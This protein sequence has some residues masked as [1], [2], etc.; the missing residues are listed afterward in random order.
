MSRTRTNPFPGL[1][2]FEFHEHSLF[3]GREEQY[4]QM[5]YKLDA[6]RFLAVVG[7]SGS[8]KSSLVRAGLLPALYSGFMMSAGSNWRV[9]LFRPKDDPIR[10]LSLALSRRPESGSESDEMQAIITEVTLR[11]G[12]LGLI[13]AARQ[14]KAPEQE[15]LL[16]VV[17]QF[18]ELFR[19]ARISEHSPHGNQA[20]AFVKLLLQARRQTEIPIYVVL[21]MRSDYLGDCA[22]FW[23]LPEA[24]NDGQYLIPRLTRE[25]R[26][27]AIRGPVMVRGAEITPQLVTQLLNDMGDSPDQLPILQHALMRT[28]D[29]WEEGGHP[30]EPIGISHYNSIGKI[31]EALSRHVEEAYGELPDARSREV[32]EKLFKCLTERAAGDREG[33][34]PTTLKE[35]R[36]V[37]NAK[38][39]EIVAVVNIFRREG[40][41]F[42]LPSQGAPLTRETL[43][44]ISHESLIRNWKRLRQWVDEEAQSVRIYERLAET[45]VLYQEGRAALWHDPDLQ[46]ALSWLEQTQPNQAWAG[47]YNPDF[48][49]AMRFLEESKAQREV[50]QIQ[51][52]KLRKGQLQRNRLIIL[53]LALITFVSVAL[54]LYANQQR[55]EALRQKE[56]FQEQIFNAERR[57]REAEEARRQAERFMNA[58]DQEPKFRKPIK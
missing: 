21:T 16:I 29:R 45:A 48:E 22:K 44:D 46:I 8:G 14:A 18:E 47:R 35:V 58:P 20:A 36:A 19:Y 34:R 17:D 56:I 55:R 37:T 42:L 50:E 15:N 54:A 31:A 5:L 39:K 43:V 49:T 41:S 26:R 27:E 33:R 32:A 30:D 10:E 12:D 7:T 28:W 4:E 2:P 11:R 24:I 6:V 52:E 23:D 9:A 51:A 40:R 57:V 53:V 3:F 1:R 38:F 13:E 25:Q